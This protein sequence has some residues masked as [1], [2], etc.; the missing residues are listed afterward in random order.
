[1]GSYTFLCICFQTFILF[2]NNLLFRVSTPNLLFTYILRHLFDNQNYQAD[3]NMPPKKRSRGRPRKYPLKN[4]GQIDTSKNDFADSGNEYHSIEAQPKRR[5]RKRKNQESNFEFEEQDTK[6][7]GYAS[8]KMP[9]REF[10]DSYGDKVNKKEPLD[11]D[12]PL[13]K[14]GN[15]EKEFVSDFDQKVH[16]VVNKYIWIRGEK[17][18]FFKDFSRYPSRKFF[19]E[20]FQRIPIGNCISVSDIQ[21]RSYTLA[22]DEEETLDIHDYQK[23]L[24]DIDLLY[25]NCSYFNEPHALIVKA[26][27]QLV[28]LIKLDLLSMKNEFRNYALRKEII[29]KINNTI[30]LKLE[31]ITEKAIIDQLK[32]AEIN[33]PEL[34]REA[35]DELQIIVPFLDLVSESDFPDYYEVIYH[36]ISFNMI[37]S[38]LNNGFYKSIFEFYK[39]LEILFMNCKTYNSSETELYGDACNLL[40]LVRY[41]FDQCITEIDSLNVDKTFETISITDVIGYKG[42]SETEDIESSLIDK[43]DVQELNPEQ[44]EL[45][46]FGGKPKLYKE[47]SDNYVFNNELSLNNEINKDQEKEDIIYDKNDDLLANLLSSQTNEKPIVSSTYKELKLTFFQDSRFPDKNVTNIGAE[48]F[49]EIYCEPTKMKTGILEG[50]DYVQINQFVIK[51]ESFSKEH[52]YSL[53]N[54]LYGKKNFYTQIQLN[55]V[56]LDIPYTEE[57]EKPP[58][59]YKCQVSFNHVKGGSPIVV[60]PKKLQSNDSSQEKKSLRCIYNV[61][62]SEKRSLVSIEIQRENRGEI[63]L[64]ETVNLWFNV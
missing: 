4:E 38:N 63:D 32:N 5:G 55:L 20:Y 1:M 25:K 24:L 52:F 29:D 45:I 59:T 54:P 13:W 8:G 42:D 46:K 19:S 15:N 47:Y 23:L 11:A 10:L 2:S 12:F 49:S 14:E 51:N 18:I 36:P 28:F 9:K 33:V 58:F 61:K 43:K 41:L 39:D 35:D 40:S 22:G 16:A 44:I 50:K 64:T 26:A 27:F 60:T 34:Q 7:N 31:N 6:S 37:K 56:D 62:L 57:A 30:M 53:K 21:K 3:I 48:S 17:N